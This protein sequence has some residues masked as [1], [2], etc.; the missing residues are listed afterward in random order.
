MNGDI[1][2]KEHIYH[3]LTVCR[4]KNK[5]LDAFAT[6]DITEEEYKKI[7]E[8]VG[9]KI[10]LLGGID[11]SKWEKEDKDGHLGM[12]CDK[13]GGNKFKFRIKETKNLKDIF[14]GYNM[15]VFCANPDCDL[16]FLANVNDLHKDTEEKDGNDT[17]GMEK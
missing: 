2:P 17:D 4:Y 10:G 13:C 12:I 16:S 6:T 11:L 3:R 5:G 1:M 8:V 7:C 9:M 15:K 14:S